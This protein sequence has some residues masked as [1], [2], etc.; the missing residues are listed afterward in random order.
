MLKL[1]ELQTV[2]KLKRNYTKKK[3]TF[4]PLI[5]LTKYLLLSISNLKLKQ[6]LKPL[7]QMGVS[8]R[9]TG[10]WSGTMEWRIEW[11]S[12]CTQL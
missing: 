11:N 12:E 6:L 4:F 1:A 7:S 9:W 10:I 2:T 8:N 5:I 3:T